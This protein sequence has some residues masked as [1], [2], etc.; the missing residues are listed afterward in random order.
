MED[1]CSQPSSCIYLLTLPAVLHC[2]FPLPV[3]DDGN[4]IQDYLLSLTGDRTVPRVFIAGECI[5]GGSDTKKLHQEG[6]L[7]PLLKSA[8]AL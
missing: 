3:T 5:G 2:L 8:G 4:A 7:V 1:A 6:K